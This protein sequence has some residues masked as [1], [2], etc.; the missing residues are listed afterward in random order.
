MMAT[1][2]Y[3]FRSSRGSADGSDKFGLA[4]LV[5]GKVDITS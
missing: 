1:H 4:A 3:P 2:F 5:V